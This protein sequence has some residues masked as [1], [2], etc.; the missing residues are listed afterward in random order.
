M[1][2]CVQIARSYLGTPMSNRHT[3]RADLDAFKREA[4]REHLLTYLIDATDEAA[5][6]RMPLLCRAV[7]YWRGNIP[8]RRPVCPACKAGVADGA[9]PGAF[10]FCDDSCRAHQR[11]RDGVLRCSAGVICH[12]T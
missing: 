2:R 1:P 4:H 7:D 10:L 6:N 8:Q 5:L 9:Q 12:S 3:R 11:R